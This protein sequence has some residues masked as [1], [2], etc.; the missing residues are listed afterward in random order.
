MISKN[1]GREQS[2][3]GRK[4][5][6]RGELERTFKAGFSSVSEATTGSKLFLNRV[7]SGAGSEDAESSSRR[8]S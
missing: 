6:Q 5:R 2:K 7:S 4:G 1:E 3:G 8:I